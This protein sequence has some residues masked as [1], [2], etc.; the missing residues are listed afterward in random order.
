M[1]ENEYLIKSIDHKLSTLSEMLDK[2]I[3]MLM[4]IVAL[5]AVKGRPLNEQIHLLDS[6]GMSPAEI[7]SCLG[8]TPNTVR[9]LLHRVR[10]D[11]NEN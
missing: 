3:S 10:R 1:T 7:A 11:R 9:V 8:K 4:K 5:D 2:K 6:I